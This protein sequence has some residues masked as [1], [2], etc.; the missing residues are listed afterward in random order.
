MDL[1]KGTESGIPMI[2]EIGEVKIDDNDIIV[3]GSRYH[4]TSEL[5]SLVAEKD[6]DGYDE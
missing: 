5:W 1:R 2:G 4:G 3:D 6:P